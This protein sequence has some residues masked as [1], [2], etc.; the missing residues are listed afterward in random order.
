MRARALRVIGVLS[1]LLS[2]CVSGHVFAANP[3]YC[4]Q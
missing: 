1:C 2:L 3:E 4:V